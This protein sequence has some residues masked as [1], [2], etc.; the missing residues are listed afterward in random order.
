M[1]AGDID[2][3][4][5]LAAALYSFTYGEGEPRIVQ[6]L[7]DAGCTI[8]HEIPALLRP[9]KHGA[10]GID[11]VAIYHRWDSQ[12]LRHAWIMSCVVVAQGCRMRVRTTTSASD[13]WTREWARADAKFDQADVP[14]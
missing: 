1:D 7:L 14:R 2:G 8:Q 10:C 3:W 13:K 12:G 4:T 6:R 9:Q 5:P 11:I